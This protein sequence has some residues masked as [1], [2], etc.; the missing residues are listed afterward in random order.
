MKDIIIEIL[1][2]MIKR[3]YQ[4]LFKKNTAWNLSLQ[5]YLN[6]SKDSLGFHLGSF[7]V[8]ANFAIQPQLEEHDVYHVLTN[9][10]TTV[11]DE[12]DMQF[13][14][15]GNGKKTPF[16][17]IVIMTG[18]LFHIKHL[19]RFLSSYKKG[20]EAHRFY[21]LD[22]SKMLALPIGNIQSAFNIK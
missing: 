10:G 17:F 22:F 8:R 11:V 1:Y 9:T 15:L 14:L 19:K 16:V 5:D 2:K 6:H 3:P 12:I 7:L 21:D 4:F 18:F 13:Y 20:K